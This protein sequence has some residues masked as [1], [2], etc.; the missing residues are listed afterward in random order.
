MSKNI[1]ASGMN[2]GTGNRQM[3][4]VRQTASNPD[5]FLFY[6]NERMD[7]ATSLNPELG[8]VQRTEHGSTL[9]TPYFNSLHQRQRMARGKTKAR[10]CDCR[11]TFII[12]KIRFNRQKIKNLHKPLKIDTR[13]NDQIDTP[14]HYYNHL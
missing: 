13:N 11:V 6:E 14:L 2:S 3:A 5:V 9:H 12:G 8:M 1:L 4:V 7:K 10:R